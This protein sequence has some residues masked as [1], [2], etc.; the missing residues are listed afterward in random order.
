MGRY[1]LAWKKPCPVMVFGE[2][3]FMQNAT[4]PYVSCDTRTEHHDRTLLFFG[5]A[6][7]VNMQ[8]LLRR[9]SSFLKS[10]K[11]RMF[12]V[13]IDFNSKENQTWRRLSTAVNIV[14]LDLGSVVMPLTSAHSVAMVGIPSSRSRANRRSSPEHIPKVRCGRI[15]FDLASKHARHL[16]DLWT[17]HG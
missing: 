11:C 16:T 9:G 2:R 13:P 7:A 14:S 8:S 4:S 10:V 12:L 6:F 15:L 17:D 3:S 5:G 1:V